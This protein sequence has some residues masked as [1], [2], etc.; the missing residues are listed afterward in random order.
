[1]NYANYKRLAVDYNAAD[2]TFSFI[3]S[4]RGVF[5]KNARIS[6]IIYGEAEIMISDYGQVDSRSTKLPDSEA[7]YIRYHKGPAVFPE[8][9]VT[10]T[11]DK[12]GITFF[13]SAPGHTDI[14][15]EGEVGWGSDPSASTFAV[16]LQGGGS[17]LRTAHG[18]AASK[19]DNALYDRLT[20][21]VLEFTGC[22][23]IRLSFDWKAGCYK[24]KMDTGGLDY[25]RGFR[26]RIHDDFY[27]RRFAVPFRPINKAHGFKTPPIGWMTWYAV[28]FGA[29]SKSVLENAKWQA[30]NLSRYG[31]NCV[32]VDW[33]WYHDDMS[34]EAL[35][36]T[37][38]FNPGKG[39][40]PEGL[41]H[42][43]DEIKAMGLVPALW[44]GA[45][46]DTNLNRMF[47][48]H[49]E[50]II[51]DEKKWCGRWWADPT[52]PGVKEE[53]IPAVFR[54]LLEWGYEAFKWDCLP[55]SLMMYDKY[56]DHL[57]NKDISSEDALRE[58]IR[59]ARSIIGDDRY[60]MSCSGSSSRD[61]LFAADM[62]DGARIGGDIFKWTEFMT[63]CVDRVYKYYVYHNV[64]WYAD[65]DN[66]VIRNEFNNMEQ[67]RSRVSFYAL[68]GVP[69]T[70][71]DNLPEL[72]EER[73]ELLRRTMPVVDIH[74]SDL[75][76]M[77]RSTPFAVVNLSVAKEYGS[78]NIVDILNNK[79][80]AEVLRLSLE[81][82][83]CLDT[84]NGT[85]YLVYDYWNRR[86]LGIASETVEISLLP[87]GSVV[88]S[89]HRR[90]ASRPVLLSTSRH[91]TQGAVDIESL[92][93]EQESMTMKGISNVVG[94]EEYRIAIYTP[95][96]C[97]AASAGYDDDPAK[98]GETAVSHAAAIT[99]D[100]GGASDVCTVSFVP[101]EDGPVCWSVAFDKNN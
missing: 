89:I 15:L 49:P 75:C 101:E 57:H 71:G 82:D 7:L 45:T 5:I 2:N 54:Q 80:E 73:V 17:V 94:G 21:S 64:L 46:N 40:Y 99:Y 6:K 100:G 16:N 43:S 83:L 58:I 22:S 51:A 86:F 20:D 50:W 93:W 97:R 4:K 85:E 44:I 47:K 30:E 24:F 69:V 34:G 27:S 79:E 74:P 96:S 63:Q 60:M 14:H 92:E 52:N 88:L 25:V 23:R 76:E 33:E 48:E 38:I 1:M 13:S 41:K 59:I 11:I 35:P 28:K 18:P 78:W 68:T 55:L 81:K 72:E 67:A 29:S 61:I 3:D 66:I 37:D 10:F 87:Y 8:L 31:A 36:G 12:E 9:N 84:S 56:H 42:V 91:I 95:D 77:A 70:L 62:F 32:W 53:F 65:A 39:K 90:E 26:T 98:R 19:V